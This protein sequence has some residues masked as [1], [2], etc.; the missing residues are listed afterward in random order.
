MSDKRYFATLPSDELAADLTTKATDFDS[1][2]EASG[3]ASAWQQSYQYYYNQQFNFLQAQNG[4]QKLGEDGEISA[5]SLNHYRNF[6]KH[7]LVLTTQAKIAYEPRAMNTDS[8]S[9]QQ[10][11]LARNILDTYTKEK[12]INRYLKRAAEAA[13]VYN[14]GYV[15]V[16]WEPSLGK[17]YSTED[18]INDAGEIKQ[19]MVYEG[20]VRIATPHPRAVS[21]DYTIEDWE[22]KNWAQVCDFR[23]KYNL[24]VRYP[25]LAEQILSID[26]KNIYSAK[27]RLMYP[28]KQDSDDI[29]IFKFYHQRCD[30]LPNGRYML[31]CD[32]DTVLYDGPIPYS[33]IPIFRIVP[34]EVLYTA[35]GYTDGFDLIGLQQGIDMMASTALSNLEAFGLQRIANPRNNNLTS[36]QLSKG[37]HV[38]NFDP[39]AGP[40]VRLDL[41]SVPPEV[42]KLWEMFER[43]GE[44]LSGINS[45]A[46]GNPESSL[47]SG[48][49]LSLVQSM[50]VQYASGFAESWANLAEDVGSFIIELI[51][52]FARTERIA[53][54]AGKHNRGAMQSYTGSDLDGI[55]RV[56]VDLGNPM[57]RTT[58]GRVEMATQLLDKSMIKSPQEYMNV[59]ETGTLEP[60]FEGPTSEIDCIRSENEIMLDGV[61]PIVLRTDNHQLHI[62]EHLT[63]LNNHQIRA[64]SPLTAMIL[65]HI[66]THENGGITPEQKSIQPPPPPQPMPPPPP[67]PQPNATITMHGPPAPPPPP[68]NGPPPGPM[69]NTAMNGAM[70]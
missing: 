66:E 65:H 62:Q 43:T 29:A 14:K 38:M 23:N 6:I 59:I 33:R 30:A 18:Y 19:R 61:E 56:T 22:E 37:L 60:V 44:T 7:V 46:R 10:T 17:P 41:A 3:L 26:D 52:D 15:E 16:T 1:Y 27:R 12:R 53:A 5:I 69:N 13:L 2:V 21:Y 32:K 36:T 67:P 25:N 40:P 11:R 70:Q 55:Q 8:K 58:A 35:E 68:M 64:S 50:A 48:V 20:D 34:G 31:Y 49:A 63:L 51:R 45:V 42:F 47:K 24:A 28:G 57:S 4:V 9:L 54:M 39:Q